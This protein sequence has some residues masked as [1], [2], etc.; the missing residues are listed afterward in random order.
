MLILYHGAT[1]VCSQ[2]AR[3]GLAEKG[4]HY[5]SRLLDLQRGD[6]FD[7]A[8]MRL[9]P[10]AVVPTLVDDDT[11]IRESSVILEYVDRIGAGPRLMPEA[12]A[13]EFATRR[14]LLRCI[15]IHAAINTMSFS[16]A[17]RDRA[18]ANSTPDQIEASLARMPDPV[19]AA[20]RRDLFQNGVR[21]VHVASALLGAVDCA[22]GFPSRTHGTSTRQI[23]GGPCSRKDD[24]PVTRRRLCPP[25]GLAT[26]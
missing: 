24:D 4:L 11:V 16:T 20:K 18:L 1:S 19:A 15:S 8:Y 3:L 14:W 7:P 12:T 26:P 13:A 22:A 6:Q 17:M 25:M 2:K 21:S 10:D 23:D 9:N 5:E